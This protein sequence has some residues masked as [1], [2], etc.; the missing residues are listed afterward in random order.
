[1]LEPD[2]VCFATDDSPDGLADARAWCKAKGMTA[3]DVRI[4][5]REGQLW[6]VSKRVVCP[7]AVSLT[8][9]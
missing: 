7:S 3:D 1:M 8:T 6:V 2:T 9:A 4:T 5:K